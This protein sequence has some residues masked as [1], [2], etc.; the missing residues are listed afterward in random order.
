MNP[1]SRD[2][3]LD[4]RSWRVWMY[5]GAPPSL[6]CLHGFTGTG[7]D[8]GPLAEALQRQIAAPDLPGHGRTDGPTEADDWSMASVVSDLERLLNELKL[9]RV[10]IVGYSMGGRVA[11]QF[12]LSHPER[13]AALVLIGATAG[14]GDPAERRARQGADEELAR[15][16]E[17]DGV[18]AFADDWERTPIIS[19]Q[20][21]IEARWRDAMRRRRREQSARGLAA[22]L[23]GLGAGAMPSTWD[24]LA[25][26]R[27]PTLL[28]TGA[29][30]DK[31][32]ALAKDLL[33]LLPQASHVAV[34][35]AGHCAHLERP[36]EVAAQI[37]AWL[38]EN[39]PP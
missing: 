31:F 16:I 29:Q 34:R 37:W 33:G 39:P 35:G 38:V 8:F 3:L 22:S 15:S 4:D 24:R 2:V 23:R 26:L 25:D 30:D 21:R 17:R 1:L 27:V 28:V 32:S 11:L 19:S 12:A 36:D 14:I 5:D 13:C 6:L 7:R 18:E 20:D 10:P 9:G